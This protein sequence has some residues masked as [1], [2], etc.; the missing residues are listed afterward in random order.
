[1]VVQRDDMP[2]MSGFCP[3]TKIDDIIAFLQTLKMATSM[4]SGNRRFRREEHGRSA[5]GRWAILARQKIW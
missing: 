4:P 1:L 5:W 2:V 3:Y